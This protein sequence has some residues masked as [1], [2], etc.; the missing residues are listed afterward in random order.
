[1]SCPKRRFT[2]TWIWYKIPNIDI[3]LLD[4]DIIFNHWSSVICH[5][6]TRITLT[7]VCIMLQ[8]IEEAPATR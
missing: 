4:N 2:F 3:Y 7:F 8:I 6:N 5:I 1:M